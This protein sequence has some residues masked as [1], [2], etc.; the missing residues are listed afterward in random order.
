MHPEELCDQHLFAE[1]R[2]LPREWGK[3]TK[4][5]PV[6]FRLGSG[7]LLWCRHF[8]G[9]LYDRYVAIVKEIQFRGKWNISYPDPPVEAANGLRPPQSEIDKARP[10]V[11][12]RIKERLSTMKVPPTWTKRNVPQH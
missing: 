10:I 8:Q 11:L 1:Y 5:V 12:A 3:V 7:H 9:M 2:E 4:K 6:E